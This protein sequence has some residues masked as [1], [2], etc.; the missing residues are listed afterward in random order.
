MLLSR[1]RLA[2]LGK[3]SGALLQASDVPESM[4]VVHVMCTQVPIHSLEKVALNDCVPASCTTAYLLSC[5]LA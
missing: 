5:D 1:R 3:P 4:L 2:L